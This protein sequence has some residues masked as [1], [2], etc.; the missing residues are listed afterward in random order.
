MNNRTN[1]FLIK[2]FVI[3]KIFKLIMNRLT[4]IIHENIMFLWREFFYVVQ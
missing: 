4:E 3:K 1:S 2:Y